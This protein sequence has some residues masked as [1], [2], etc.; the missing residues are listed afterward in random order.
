MLKSKPP[1]QHNFE[2]LLVDDDAVIRLLHRKV[3]R[4]SEISATIIN[5][6]DGREAAQHLQGKASAEITYLV[7][8][9]LNMPVMD[10]WEFLEEC[11]KNYGHLSLHVVVVTSSVNKVDYFKA[12]KYQE[13]IAFCTKPFKP[14]TWDK[15]MASKELKNVFPLPPPNLE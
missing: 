10:G 6:K 7:L 2:I 12:I 13:V 3:I 4:D 5:C 14:A 11:R 15:L 1:N 9:D 8:L